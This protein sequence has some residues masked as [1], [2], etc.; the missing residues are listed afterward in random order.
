MSVSRSEPVQR[1]S[2]PR[3]LLVPFL[4]TLALTL[5]RLTGDLLRWPAGEPYGPF[6]PHQI[7]WLVPVFGA[8]FGVKLAKQTE[9]PTPKALF[10]R[11]LLPSALFI[12]GLVL[13]R[14]T[15]GAMAAISVAAVVLVRSIWPRL[16]S[17]LLGYALAARVP[18]AIAMLAATTGSWETVYDVAPFSL[19]AGLL[20]QLTVWIAFT[21]LVGTSAAGFVLLHKGHRASTDVTRSAA[22]S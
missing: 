4:G 1:M 9:A 20:P 7:F 18:V 8:Y 10:S 21:V 15:S 19:A 11:T 13:F 3:L 2:L 14:P 17:A 22:L 12:S 6:G 16:N 5:F